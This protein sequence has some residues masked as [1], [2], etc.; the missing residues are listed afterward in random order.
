MFFLLPLSVSPKR[1]GREENEK[2]TRELQVQPIRASSHLMIALTRTT[3]SMDNFCVQMKDSRICSECKS[4]LSLPAQ[5]CVQF[6]FSRFDK[7]NT[8]AASKK[9]EDDSQSIISISSSISIRLEFFFP[10]S[11]RLSLWLLLYLA[12]WLFTPL[13][14]QKEA[15]KE[16][17]SRRRG[18]F[19]ISKI[20][21]HSLSE[22]RQ[23]ARGK[24]DYER[25]FIHGQ[26][27][28]DF[29]KKN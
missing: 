24:N 20:P 22:F 13:F 29:S 23:T 19:T 1:N 3:W 12:P 2:F 10:L 28:H 18:I 5:P 11:L 16:W 27:L 7:Q 17:K 8:K 4:T 14:R 15:E 6:F 21:S 25:K 26:N 9:I